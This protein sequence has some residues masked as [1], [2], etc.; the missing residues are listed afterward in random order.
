MLKVLSGFAMR[1]IITNS[2]STICS[3]ATRY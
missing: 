1:Q 2:L 3:V